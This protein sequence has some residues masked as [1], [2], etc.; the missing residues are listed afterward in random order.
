MHKVVH[1]RLPDC[2]DILPNVANAENQHNLRN[3]EVLDQFDFKTKF[4]KKIIVP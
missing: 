3:N 2:L 4:K 1:Y